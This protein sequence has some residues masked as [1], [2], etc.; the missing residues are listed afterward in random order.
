MCL[1][2]VGRSRARTGSSTGSPC[3]VC[4][5]DLLEIKKTGYERILVAGP[6]LISRG[7]RASIQQLSAEFRLASRC[8]PFSLALDAGKLL[9]LSW[10]E[11]RMI[12]FQYQRG[13]IV[14]QVSKRRHVQLVQN[15][16]MCS[17]VAI[18]TVDGLPGAHLSNIKEITA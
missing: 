13:G 9:L 18:C 11:R 1:C 16:P 6:D 14:F 15:S 12:S 5:V 10:E 4:A 2:Y 17:Q 3:L 8:H 7:V